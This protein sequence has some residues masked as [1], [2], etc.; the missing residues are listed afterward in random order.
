MLLLFG[1]TPIP[2]NDKKPG[3]PCGKKS[4]QEFFLSTVGDI[5]DFRPKAT[6]FQSIWPE[7]TSATYSMSWS[8]N[9]YT[10]KSE[11]KNGVGWHVTCWVQCHLTWWQDRISIDKWQMPKINILAWSYIAVILK[12]TWCWST[13][14]QTFGKWWLGSWLFLS[15]NSLWRLCSR[16]C[17]ISITSQVKPGVSSYRGHYVPNEKTLQWGHLNPY[18]QWLMTIPTK[19]KHWELIDPSTYEVP[20][21]HFLS[22]SNRGLSSDTSGASKNVFFFPGKTGGAKRA[23]F[24]GALPF[25][26]RER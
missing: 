6:T 17:W 21:I 23:C 12:S 7:T 1:R 8:T 24:S 15:Y 3:K 9:V 14:W 19:G 11:T 18:Y 5:G 10:N 20:H 2:G 25:G 26:F 16:H 13:S 22:S 4:E